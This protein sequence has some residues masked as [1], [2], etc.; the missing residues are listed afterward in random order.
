[1]TARAFHK[2]VQRFAFA[3]VLFLIAAVPAA[4]AEF[5]VAFKSCPDQSEDTGK[6]E[7]R[8][9]AIASGKVRGGRLALRMTGEIAPGDPERLAK[10]IAANAEA[11]GSWGSLGEGN[12]ITLMLSGEAGDFD[13][14]IALGRFLQD[15]WIHTRIVRGAR[16]TGA[17]ALAFM[18]GRA[19]WGRLTRPAVERRLE[20]GGV[21][22]FASPL[23]GLDPAQAAPAVARLRAL[24]AYA[25]HAAIAPAILKKIAALES[26]D[27][28]TIDTVFRAKIANI[29]VEGVRPPAKME[30]RNYIDACYA[31]G[32]WN[33]GVFGAYDEPPKL[34]TTGP[35]MPDAQV[36][37]RGSGFV[38]VTAVTSFGNLDYWCAIATGQSG[39]VTIRRSDVKAW[40][41]KY[42][43]RNSLLAGN[44]A[45]DVMLQPDEIHYSKASAGLHDLPATY[46]LR[47]LAHPPA[48]RLDAIAD[49]AFKWDPFFY[50][51]D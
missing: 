19:M 1:M 51:Q 20:A 3:A 8:N 2:E 41:S 37:R 42:E 40:L 34:D 4:A 22:A 33:Y 49:P 38:V 23:A 43:G 9:C 6:S 48:T 28:F 29:G 17:C 47:L 46:G 32:D 13:A 12:F 10:A 39:K 24:V 35:D 5:E 14:G 18:G 45:E 36:F 15:G 16:C 27:R 25:E 11:G 21:L 7:I 31:Q 30:D 44:A 50:P 26:A